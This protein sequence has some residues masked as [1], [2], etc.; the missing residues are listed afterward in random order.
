MNEQLSKAGYRPS[1][2]WLPWRRTPGPWRTIN[3]VGCSLT[4]A[5]SHVLIDSL[6]KRSQ[7]Y[8]EC[9]SNFEQVRKAQIAFAP[10]DRTHESPVNAAFICESFLRKALREPKIAN[11]SPQ[12]LQHMRGHIFRHDANV[13]VEKC[14]GLHFLNRQC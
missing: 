11:T 3:F 13:R 7:R 12:D 9:G 1:L 8:S 5:M 10:L 4:S 2:L 14:L 6:Q